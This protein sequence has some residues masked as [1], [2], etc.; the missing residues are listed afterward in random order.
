MSGE[1]KYFIQEARLHRLYEK[2]E[3][4][5]PYIEQRE[6]EALK[7]RELEKRI[8]RVFTNSIPNKITKMQLLI[9]KL[10]EIE[11]LLSTNENKD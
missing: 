1:M 11:S 7:R 2:Y 9:T 8:E 10:I 4:M 5:R 3:R 6:L